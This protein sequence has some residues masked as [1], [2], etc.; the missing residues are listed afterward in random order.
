MGSPFSY[1]SKHRPKCIGLAEFRQ[2]N[3]FDQLEGNNR[4]PGRAFLTISELLA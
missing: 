3:E 2:G 1:I 4:N